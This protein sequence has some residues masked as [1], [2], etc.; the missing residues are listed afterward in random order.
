MSFLFLIDDNA[1][2][3]ILYTLTRL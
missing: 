3:N 1:K 2:V